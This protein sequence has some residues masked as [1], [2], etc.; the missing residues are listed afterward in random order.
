MPNLTYIDSSLTDRKMELSKLYTALLTEDSQ[1][2]DERELDDFAMSREKQPEK[3]SVLEQ[4]NRHS[5]LVLMGRAGSGKSTF[6]D[7][8]VLC[9]AGELLERDGKYLELL[10]TPPPK[11]PEADKEPPAPHWEHGALFPVKI[12][13]RKFASQDLPESG[14]KAM[15][16]HLWAYLERELTD[17]DLADYFPKFKQQLEKEGGLLLFDGLDEVANPQECCIQ[18]KQ[19]IEEVALL[20]EKCRIVVTS[21][22]YAYDKKKW[23]LDS[24][25]IVT[26]L[27][28]FTKGQISQFIARWYDYLGQQKLIESLT[29]KILDHERFLRLARQPLL[30]TLMA[31]LNISRGQLP[32]KRAQLYEE[33]IQLLL[34][35]W[36]QSHSSDATKD[37]TIL[38]E[39]LSKLLNV[40]QSDIRRMLNDLAFDAHAHQPTNVEGT[41]NLTSDALSEGI[42][43]LTIGHP[44]NTQ[45]VLDFID[46]RTG[47]LEGWGISDDSDKRVYR[48]PHRTFQEY[49]AACSL[50]QKYGSS[51]EI[52]KLVKDEPNRWREVALLA[53]ATR[54]VE[55]FWNLITELCPKPI[56]KPVP[57]TCHFEENKLM[58]FLIAGQAIDESINLNDL[59]EAENEFVDRVCGWLQYIAETDLPPLERVTAGQVLAKLGDK[60]AGVEP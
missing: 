45:E 57:E 25:F 29:R 17:M 4:L 53:A 43:K 39:G 21:R 46:Q 40:A 3:L 59:S 18:L 16:K 23:K 20:Y 5:R 26:E 56:P 22:P 10:K 42:R 47:I 30:L 6:V 60:R 44:V 7:F 33:T 2:K 9:M 12:V 15:A 27:A 51:K 41:A 31:N 28:F 11:E 13:L 24:S 1:R 38:S 19:V 35:R 36:E 48:F 34:E 14:K 52:A 8:V 37:E 54:N 49:L 50:N 32:E 55:S 58:A